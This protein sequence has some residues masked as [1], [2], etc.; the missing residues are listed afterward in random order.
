MPEGMFFLDARTNDMYYRI[1]SFAD[2]YESLMRSFQEWLRENEIDPEGLWYADIFEVKT[3][4]H[5]AYL[6]VEDGNIY[7]VGAP[8]DSKV[9]PFK[10]KRGFKRWIKETWLDLRCIIH[11]IIHN[12]I[13]R[14]DEDLK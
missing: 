9:N 13:V 10:R 2:D 8:K 11:A 14:S 1:T 6:E 5:I 3:A 7:L 4:R 12:E